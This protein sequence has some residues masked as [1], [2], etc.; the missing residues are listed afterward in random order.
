MPIPRRL[1][2]AVNRNAA[3]LGYEVVPATKRVSARYPDLEP[4]FLELHAICSPYTATSVERMYALYQSVR[5]LVRL[6]IDGD[7]VETGV[8]RGGSSMLAALTLERCGDTTRRLW[9]YDTYSGMPEPTARD[10]D[11]TGR[12]AAEEWDQHPGHLSDDLAC[13]ASLD[14]VRRNLSSAG[15][16]LARFEFVQGLVQ[17]TIPARVPAEIALLRLDTDWYESTRHELEHLYPRLRVGGVLILD[18]YGHWAGS[19][20][21]VDEYFIRQPRPLMQRLDY[22]GRA[23]VKTVSE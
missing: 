1:S 15:L 2:Q 19:R 20:Q 7:F 5:H 23:G 12:S 10:V 21:A 8:W 14:E 9:L 6:G 22:G 11:Y 17:D 13:E 16:N 18:D 3:R 4:E